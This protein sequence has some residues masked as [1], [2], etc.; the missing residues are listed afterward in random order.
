MLVDFNRAVSE[1]KTTNERFQLKMKSVNKELRNIEFAIEAFQYREASGV[2]RIPAI[3]W[4][5]LT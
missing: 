4:L 2:D 1:L 3:V 5:R